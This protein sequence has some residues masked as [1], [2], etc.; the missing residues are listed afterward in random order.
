[1][2]GAV[3]EQVRFGVEWLRLLVETLGALVIGVGVVLTVAGLA[4][5]ALSEHGLARTA[6][7]FSCGSSPRKP[8][9]C[10]PGFSC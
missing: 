8:S 4:R 7:R 2:F 6:L 1:M 9:G 3:E 10:G 5:H